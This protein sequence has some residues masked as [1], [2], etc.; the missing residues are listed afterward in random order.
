VAQAD[1]LVQR[2]FIENVPCQKL[3]QIEGIGPVIATALVAAVGNAHEFVPMGATWLHG[4]G[5]SLCSFPPEA[6]SACSESVNG[7]IGTCGPY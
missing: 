4:S 6:K 7:A 2:V 5:S 1:R 3:A